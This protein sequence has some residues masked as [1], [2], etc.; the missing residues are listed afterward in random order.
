MLRHARHGRKWDG[1]GD[2]GAQTY[3]PLFDR[4]HRTRCPRSFLGH[5]WPCGTD[6]KGL[7]PCAP[8]KWPEFK[9]LLLKVFSGRSCLEAWR[10]ETA[11]AERN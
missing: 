3:D 6:V 11:I 4:W 2:P 1:K 10:E 5:E 9:G 7:G 8:V